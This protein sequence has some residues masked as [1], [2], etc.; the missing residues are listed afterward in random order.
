MASHLRALLATGALL[1][2]SGAALAA[3][4]TANSNVN[5]RSG[6]GQQYQVLDVLP[7]GETVNLIGC[8]EA[9]CEVSMGREGTG[10]ALAELFDFRG[11]PPYVRFGGRTTSTVVIEE[12][13]PIEVRELAIG[14]Y[15]DNRP[16]YIRDGYYYWGGR[17]YGSRPGVGAWRDRSWRRWDDR[18]GWGDRGRRGW[19][20][21]AGRDRP[22]DTRG[23]YTNRPPRVDEP[24]WR[25]RDRDRPGD[26]RGGY[27]N[28]PPRVDDD[29]TRGRGAG[30]GGD[31][32]DDRGGRVG[33]LERGGDGRMNRVE[34]VDRPEPRDR[35]DRMGLD[36]AGGGAERGG[37]GAGSGGAERGGR[38]EGRE[39]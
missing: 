15:W 3:S 17:W 34:R 21:R 37:R 18:R 25:D 16:Y 38:G 19:D 26:T 1:L 7:A 11:R 32:F 36:R 12:D 24:R 2:S 29:A 23:G 22:G 6:P 39:R 4:A 8:D 33:G 5:V 30:R 20:D 13:D 10:F 27:T 9:W 14:G 31:R 35:G 28:R